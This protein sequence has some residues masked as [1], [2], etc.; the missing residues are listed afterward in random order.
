M[1]MKY[2][3]KKKQER[4]GEISDLVSFFPSVG[5][6]EGEQVSIYSQNTRILD[7]LCKLQPAYYERV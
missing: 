2:R 3:R 7:A 6:K 5:L 4:S 1:K